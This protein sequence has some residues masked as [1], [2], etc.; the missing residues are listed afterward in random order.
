M[1]LRDLISLV[2]R[3][4]VDRFRERQEENEFLRV[5]T[6]EEIEQGA[7]RGAIRSGGSEL[8]PQGVDPEVAVGTAL[9]AFEDGLYFVLI[10]REQCRAL[11]E[12][13]VVGEDST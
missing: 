9:Q 10:D 6:A 12:Q 11:D 4:Q 13:V 5:L 3:L 1:T 7:T 2:V 8:E